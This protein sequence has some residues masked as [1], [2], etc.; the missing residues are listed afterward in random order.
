MKKLLLAAFVLLGP[1]LNAQNTPVPQP[2][3]NS[4]LKLMFQ[5]DQRMRS[6][7]RLTSEERAQIKRTDADRLLA[8]RQMI[9]ADQLH[10]ALDYRN[11]SLILQ[12]GRK[13][14]DY[15]LA[16]TL[17]V[18]G[19]SKGDR[20]CNWLSAATLDRYLQ[21]I[22]QPQIYGTQFKL[23]SPEQMTQEPY[24]T[25][26]VTDALRKELGVP[27]LTDQRKQIEMF[28]QQAGKKAQ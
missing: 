21:S 12:H 9:V 20:T 19:S 25:D 23:P 24:T 17:A 5:E 13:S 16:H 4:E 3:S 15:L 14:E 7:G 26:L 27:P 6:G 1:A 22:G 28:Q 8:V 11:A 2:E 18:I 10:T